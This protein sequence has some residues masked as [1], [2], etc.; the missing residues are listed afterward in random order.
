MVAVEMVDAYRGIPIH[1]REHP[2]SPIPVIHPVSPL[3][4]QREPIMAEPQPLHQGPQQHRVVEQVGEEVLRDRGLDGSHQP[5]GGVV[6]DDGCD[7]AAGR[8]I[9]PADGDVQPGLL[10]R[11]Q[12]VV[13]PERAAGDDQQHDRQGHAP[14]SCAAHNG[15]GLSRRRDAHGPGS[16]VMVR[17]TGNTCWRSCRCRASR[18]R[19]SRL[20][21]TM[22]S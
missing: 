11:H 6:V 8:Q 14:P 18:N 20:G 15:R 12:A 3:A 17:R 16:T 2:L 21:V 4:L 22:P 7:H 9:E 19:T 10:R 1:D 5:G 13:R